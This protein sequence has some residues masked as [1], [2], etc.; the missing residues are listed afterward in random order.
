MLAD[1]GH[2]ERHHR[3]RVVGIDEQLRTGRAGRA[4]Q[5]A[6]VGHHAR[7]L[8]EHAGDEHRGG[9]RSDA[10]REALIVRRLTGSA[11]HPVALNFPEGEYL[12]GLLVQV[13]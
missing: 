10:G 9:A 13:D 12:K 11:D 7:G 5:L 1:R 3:E 2:L 6:Q 8:E 4:R